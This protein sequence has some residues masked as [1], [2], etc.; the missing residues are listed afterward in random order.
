VR[1]VELGANSPTTSASSL[2]YVPPAVINPPGQT[3][4]IVAT[5][6][7]TPSAEPSTASV[8]PSTTT[9]PRLTQDQ[10]RAIVVI[11]GDMGE[12]TGFLTKTADGPVVVTNNHV[13]AANPHIKIM[14]AAGTPITILSLKG[15][16]DRD[17]VMFAIKDDNYSYLDLGTDIEH[18]VLTGDEVIAPGNSQGGE[19]VLTTNG[20]VLGVGPDRVEVSNPIYHGNS[21][22]PIFHV[23]SGKVIGVI[24]QAL[25]VR[26]AN[27]ID[28]A[29]YAD[30]KSAI[31]GPMRYFGFRLDS[32][33]KWEPYDWNRFL[34]ETAFLKEF[35]LESRC[36]DSCLNG[37]NYEKAHL[38]SDDINEGAP[39]SRFYLQNEKLRTALETYHQ[40]LNDADKSQRLSAQ[41]ELEI[42]LQSV[43]DKDMMAIQSPGNFY[44]FSQIRAKEELAYRTAL[45]GEIDNFGNKLSD[46][47]H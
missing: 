21:G 18:T 27:A 1:V 22:G 24:T 40:S 45:K 35:Q 16:V 44:G 29:S 14:T 19:V 2:N 30:A 20:N 32:V 11:K 47:G 17:L 42:D 3:P 10:A 43:A 34:N 38:T 25:K 41:R 12:G 15:A 7:P 13:I 31:T 37:A 39:N 6:T 36:L 5:S 28:K 26:V 4:G 46:M 8:I 23:K 9:P 33:P